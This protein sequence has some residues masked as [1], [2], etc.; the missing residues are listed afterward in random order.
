LDKASPTQPFFVKL[1]P[2]SSLLNPANH[3]AGRSGS[4]WFIHAATKPNTKL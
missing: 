4:C 2:F 3:S 1:P